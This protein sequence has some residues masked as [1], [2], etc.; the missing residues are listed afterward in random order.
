MTWQLEILPGHSALWGLELNSATSLSRS[1]P[2]AA[3]LNHVNRPSLSHLPIPFSLSL[4][5]GY[6]KDT[7]KYFLITNEIVSC[8]CSKPSGGRDFPGGPVF[9]ASPSDAGGEG[10]IPGG[11]AGIP[12]ASRPKKKKK[13][14]KNIEQKQYCVKFNGDVKDGPHQKTKQNK[15]FKQTKPSSGS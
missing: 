14:T 9:G 12:H 3:H 7:R 13:T 2:L 6:W 10:S 1:L 4:K 5:A 15:I 8:F 11:G